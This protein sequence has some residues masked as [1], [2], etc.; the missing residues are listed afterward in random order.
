MKKNRTIFTILIV[1]F[2]GIVSLSMNSNPVKAANTVK[3]YLNSNSYVYNHK[4]QRLRGKYIKKNKAVAAPGKLRKTNSVKRYYIMKDNSSTGV[5]N[6][7]ENLFNY[8]YWL[9]YK[10]IK[11]Q[12][13]YRIGYNRY[14]KCINVKSIY[15]KDLPSLYAHKANEL[16][17]NHATVI[18]KDPKTINQKHIYALKEVSKN[19]AENA[20]V[21]P[22]NKKLVVDDTTGFDNMYAET[23]HI[24]NTKYYVYAGDIVK[25]PRHPVYS[26]PFKSIINGI[27]TLY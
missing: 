13:Y 15:S 7:N 4:G 12:E 2:L 1:A 23:Y 5:M 26:H 17:T 21:L 6:S 24:K 11:K 20:Y 18:T 19:R 25:R 27:K 3:L 10:K 22:K 9:P 16:I 8:L 14:I